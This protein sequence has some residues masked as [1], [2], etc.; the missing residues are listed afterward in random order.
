MPSNYRPEFDDDEIDDD[1][2][3]MIDD[4][5][6]DEDILDALGIDDDELYDDIEEFDDVGGPD[7]DSIVA[8][9]QRPTL[10]QTIAALAQVAA[11]KLSATVF[12]GLA[13]LREGQIKQIAP[14]WAA[15]DAEMR[16]KIMQRMSDLSEAA[17]YLDYEQI[18]R[19]A[20]KDDEA[21]VRA[22]AAAM[23]WQDEDPAT[24]EALLQLVQ[25]DDETAVRTAAASALGNHLLLGEYEELPQN[26]C[27]RT[28]EAL[29]EIINN[30]DEE[31]ELRR[32]ALEAL[33]NSSHDAVPA[34]IREAYESDHQPMQVSALFAMGRTYDEQWAPSVLRELSS[35]DP[36]MRFEA[37]RAV[38][39]L[40][41]RAAVPRLDALAH[42]N[43]SDIQ[44]AAV[45][46]LGQIGGAQAKHILNRLAADNISDD[47]RALVEEALENAELADMSL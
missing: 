3:D 28:Q 44:A 16:L 23:L 4:R 42:E 47:L 29:L 35:P 41:L 32:R 30:Q 22:V 12:Y 40:E 45:T 6:T 34:L 43:D 15:L 1:N 10:A 24:T 21:D 25:S 19:F 13:G 11:D 5:F 14:A 18:A 37:A 31:L 33:S 46:A 36:E 20:L 26:V 7:D 27:L 9:R 2:D 8:P 39:E 17:G 38:G